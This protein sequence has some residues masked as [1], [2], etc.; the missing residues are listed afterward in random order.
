MEIVHSYNFHDLLKVRI[1][2]HRPG[3]FDS[4]LKKTFSH[5]EVKGLD[6]IDLS[7][8]IG[9]FLPNLKDCALIDGKYFVRKDYVFYKSMYKIAWWET[10]IAGIEKETTHVCIQS[11][12]FGRVVIPGETIYNL[13][14]FKLATKGYPLLHGSG[15]GRDGMAYLFSGR[16]GTG[17]TL[18]TLNFV[19]R[20]FEYYSDDSV[21]LGDHEIFGFVV[22]FNLRFTYDV[23]SLLA[24]KFSPKTKRELFF[25]RLLYFLTLGQISLFTTLEAKQV[26]P[27]AL[28]N[29]AGLKK[30]Y[31]LFQGPEF[32]I[33]KNIPLEWTITDI[34][35]NLQFECPEL[36]SLL[37][38]YSY[39]FPKNPLSHFWEEMI[40]R[41]YV[42]LTGV[43]THRISV[44]VFYSD[45][46]FNRIYEEVTG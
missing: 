24:I 34:L 31:I 43:E 28:R 36:I 18:S 15:I 41:I 19:R 38:A 2:I 22:P 16:G 40:Q 9:P 1:L 29:R 7:I 17:K 8:K 23:E 21:I 37:L 39:C 27:H 20:G 32:S 33:E 14:R 11:N 46:I 25:K 3:W 4:Y 26:F 45:D 10:E 5:Y 12:A 35:I 44:P 42:S 13:I 6:K 30:V